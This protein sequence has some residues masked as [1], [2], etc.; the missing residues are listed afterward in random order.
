[1][2]ASNI[3]PP[4]AQCVSCQSDAKVP[5]LDGAGWEIA[6]G[7]VSSVTTGAES[8]SLRPSAIMGNACICF[9]AS[10]FRTL[11]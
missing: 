5:W 1:M 9:A 8:L 3:G 11:I 10:S 7:L 2:S 4:T 6:D